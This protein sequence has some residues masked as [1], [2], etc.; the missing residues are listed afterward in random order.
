MKKRKLINTS[1]KDEI[2][3]YTE[4]LVISQIWEI[5]EKEACNDTQYSV[6]QAW[7]MMVLLAETG[8]TK[9]GTDGVEV[10][11]MSL[12]CDL[13]NLWCFYDIQAVIPQGNQKHGSVAQVTDLRVEMQIQE[14]FSMHL[15]QEEK[16]PREYQHRRDI[17]TEGLLLGDMFWC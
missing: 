9:G 2:L 7:Y 6:L 16:N 4:V 11:I 3:Y 8:N 5:R 1:L 14:L 17:E 13:L 10:G 12:V 15:E